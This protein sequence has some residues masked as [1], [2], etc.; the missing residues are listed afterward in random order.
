MVEM[1]LNESP[2]EGSSRR[3]IESVVIWDEDGEKRVT[4]ESGGKEVQIEQGFAGAFRSS[5]T[6]AQQ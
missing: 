2:V 3:R 5:A 1:S 4:I 6:C